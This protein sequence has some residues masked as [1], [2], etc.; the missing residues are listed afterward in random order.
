MLARELNQSI[1]RRSGRRFD[2]ENATKQEAFSDEVDAGST[3]KMR[4]NKK[5]FPTKWP[6]V[7]RRKC[8]QTRN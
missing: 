3:Q 2:A 7:R 5:H 4:P 1:F 8:D 6:P